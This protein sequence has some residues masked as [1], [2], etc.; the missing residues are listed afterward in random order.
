MV[1]PLSEFL[2]ELGTRMPYNFGPKIVSLCKNVPKHLYHQLV[3]LKLVEELSSLLSL[4]RKR[5][6]LQFTHIEFVKK[7]IFDN[8]TNH[9][10]V[11][12]FLFPKDR[13][14]V[15]LVRLFSLKISTLAMRS[16]L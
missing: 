7:Y 4:S 11:A 14:P 9:N 10:M 13:K 15:I 6:E 2:I 3:Y 8:K 16:Q 5:L 12:N 1:T